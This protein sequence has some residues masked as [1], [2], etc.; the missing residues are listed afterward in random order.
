MQLLK[1]K[2]LIRFDI[3]DYLTQESDDALEHMLGTMRK[4]GMP[5][6]YGLVAR[7]VDALKRNGRVALLH[8]L[9]QEPALGFHSTSHSA[10][11]TI[12]EEL[13]LLPYEAARARFV[14]RERPG[15]RTVVDQVGQPRYFTQPGGNWVPEAA[16]VL[17]QLGMD[18]YFT[19]S[20]NSYV[21]DL[22]GP[23]WYG[24]VLLYSFPVVNPRP[25]G[26]GLPGNLNEAISLVEEQVDRGGVFMV[27]LHPT[28]LVTQKFW[29]AVNFAHGTTRDPLIPAPVRPLSEQRAALESFAKY[30]QEIRR[31]DIEW[32]NSETLR[33]TV[34]PKRAISVR[35][36]ELVAAVQREGFGPVKVRGGYLSAAEALY[37]LARFEST[38]GNVVVTIGQVDAPWE[39]QAPANVSGE[40]LPETRRQWAATLIVQCVERQGRLPDRKDLGGVTL[41]QAFRSFMDEN[42]RDVRPV[43]LDYIKEPSKLHWD[44]PIFPENFRPWRLYRDAQ[45][46]AWTLK[47]ADPV[48]A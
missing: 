28:E 16:E 33:A 31:L 21:V 35:R 18:L 3:E 43:F 36:A 22:P 8:E 2:G 48:I 24:N 11:P 42:L 40:R 20:F 26:L 19:D 25:F 47:P 44:W 17:P 23:Y 27:M 13:A 29:D 4:A 37:A 7:K 46:L 14:E 39:W 1:A 34:E 10:H 5:A 32:Y 12:A 41:E 9:S 38:P 45:R 30:V 6:S 15:V